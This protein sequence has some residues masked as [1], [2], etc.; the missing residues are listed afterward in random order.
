LLAGFGAITT[1]AIA[2]AAEINLGV[3]ATAASVTYIAIYD[4]ATGGT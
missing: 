3:A 4:A 1:G 2:N